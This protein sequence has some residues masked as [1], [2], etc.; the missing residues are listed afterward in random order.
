MIMK[1]DNI[2]KPEILKINIL[3]Q[4]HLNPHNRKYMSEALFLAMSRTSQCLVRVTPLNAFEIV[5][6]YIPTVKR[7]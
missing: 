4:V 6:T 3:C 2:Q 1:P 7:V 5:L